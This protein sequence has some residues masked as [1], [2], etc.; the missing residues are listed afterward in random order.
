MANIINHQLQTLNTLVSY[1][2]S[3]RKNNERQCFDLLSLKMPHQ[4]PTGPH[5][6][7]VVLQISCPVFTY[8]MFMPEVQALLS[9]HM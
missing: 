1:N 8:S 9:I 6:N 2:I 4:N 7:P 3:Y 5:Q